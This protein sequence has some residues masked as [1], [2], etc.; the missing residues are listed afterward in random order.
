[1]NET[2]KSKP[3]RDRHKDWRLFH[4]KGIDVGCGPDP[5]TVDGSEILRWDL[6]DGDAMYLATIRDETLDFVYSSHCLEHLRNVPLAL[7]N[8]SRVTKMF[9]FVFVVVPEWT[10][11]EHRQ[12]PSPHNPDHKASFSIISAPTPTNHPHYTVE[13]MNAIGEKAGLR[14]LDARIEMDGFEWRHHTETA[15]FLDQTMGNALAQAVFIFHKVT[16]IRR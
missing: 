14:L 15:P 8:W 10:L 2:A 13:N 12:W 3:C 6:S 5:L 9:G 11:Y 4:G 16:S 7:R 1:M